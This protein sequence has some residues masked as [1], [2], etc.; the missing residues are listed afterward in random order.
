MIQKFTPEINRDPLEDKAFAVFEA[1]IEPFKLA[2]KDAYDNAYIGIELGRALY[3]A[4]ASPIRKVWDNPHTAVVYSFW[5]NMYIDLQ[6]CD[7]LML[8]INALYKQADVYFNIIAP[9]A[10]AMRIDVNHSYPV[11]WNRDGRYNLETVPGDIGL[12]EDDKEAQLFVTDS[13]T[14]AEDMVGITFD[15]VT[16][17]I[18]DD[19][20]LKIL[21]DVVYPGLFYDVTIIK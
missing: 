14:D 17:N 1:M 2:V 6:T 8:F 7:N 10:I 3:N 9:L 12:L 21:R 20:F 15:R 19:A 16:I 18:N 13:S 5:H 11:W 4:H